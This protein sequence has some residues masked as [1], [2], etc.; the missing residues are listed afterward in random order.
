MGN[1]DGFIKDFGKKS[2]LP[3]RI[4]QTRPESVEIIIILLVS[5]EAYWDLPTST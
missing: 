4:I 2:F 5:V 1:E 3:T